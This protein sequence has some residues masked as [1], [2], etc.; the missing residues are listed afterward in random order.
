MIWMATEISNNLAC[1]KCVVVQLYD[2]KML[3]PTYSIIKPI[4]KCQ[5]NVIL[6]ANVSLLPIS[7]STIAFGPSNFNVIAVCCNMKLKRF[8]LFSAAFQM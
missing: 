5:V 6:W 3:K 2:E 7:A 1:Q 4:A 8:I